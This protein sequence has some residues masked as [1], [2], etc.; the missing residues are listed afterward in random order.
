LSSL[1]LL[2]GLCILLFALSI[3]RAVL[4][5]PSR[6]DTIMIAIDTSGSMRADD[7]KPSRFDATISAV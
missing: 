3:P 2:L 7:I 6:L 4:Y 1:F 5:V